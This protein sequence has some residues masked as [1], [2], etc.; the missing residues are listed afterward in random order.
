MAAR[1][2][3]REKNDELKRDKALT[4]CQC[5]TLTMLEMVTEMVTISVDGGDGCEIC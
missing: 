5:V 2:F 4:E 3:Y 1:D